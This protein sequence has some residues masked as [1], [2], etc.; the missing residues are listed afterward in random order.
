MLKNAAARRLDFLTLFKWKVVHDR[1][2]G[3]GK[4]MYVIHKTARTYVLTLF[5]IQLISINIIYLQ[6]SI[7]FCTFVSRKER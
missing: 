6:M 1:Y 2:K 3:R 7:L 4:P 5:H